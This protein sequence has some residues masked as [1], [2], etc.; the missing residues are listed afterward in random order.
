MLRNNVY[1]MKKDVYLEMIKF[2][3][4]ELPLEGCGLISGIE[5]LGGTLWCLPNPSKS[6]SKFSISEKAMYSIM[7]Q[8]E[9]NLEKLT[10]VFH[11]HPVTSAYPST[12]D[13]RNN[14]YS[15]IAYI[16]VSFKR[17]QPTV[18]CFRIVDQEKVLPLKLS[19][20]GK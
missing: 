14:P 8:V 13:I 11:S 6:N 3:K 20:V 18:G 15:N 7:K 16:I 1:E 10:G 9:K 12:S 17:N 19:I 4:Q 2:C 5:G